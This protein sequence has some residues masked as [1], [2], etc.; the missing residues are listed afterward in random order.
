M[1]NVTVS[2]ECNTSL[3]L[4]KQFFVGATCPVHEE[5][6]CER[7]KGGV[8]KSMFALLCIWKGF[9]ECR[10]EHFSINYK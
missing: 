3:T 1:G 7:W 8:H 4:R 9:C 6:L 10:C 2:I 5:A